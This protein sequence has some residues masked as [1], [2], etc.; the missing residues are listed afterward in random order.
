MIE[1]NIFSDSDSKIFRNEEIIFIKYTKLHYKDKL[2]ISNKEIERKIL[3]QVYKLKSNDI[4]EGKVLRYM[5]SL[6]LKLYRNQYIQKP[7]TYDKMEW[8]LREFAEI[9][10]SDKK[11]LYEFLFANIQ[12]SDNFKKELDYFDDSFLYKT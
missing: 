10:L 8:L 11:S 3:G 7:T 4:D 6:F 1:V 9:E 12:W 2:S 5:I